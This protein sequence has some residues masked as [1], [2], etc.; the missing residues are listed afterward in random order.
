MMNKKTQSKVGNCNI[1][2]AK[3][4]VSNKQTYSLIRAL[5]ETNTGVPV[6]PED[7][8]SSP[9]SGASRAQ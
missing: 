5:V 8:P 3:P 4:S 9:R 7:K 6:C 1:R 2:K